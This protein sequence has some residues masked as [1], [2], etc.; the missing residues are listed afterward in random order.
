[1]AYYLLDVDNI[2][3]YVIADRGKARQV[4]LKCGHDMGM[5]IALRPTS[6]NHGVTSLSAST[7]REWTDR[8]GASGVRRR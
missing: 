1:M 7:T 6:E 5:V 2:M 3:G 8:I 4:L